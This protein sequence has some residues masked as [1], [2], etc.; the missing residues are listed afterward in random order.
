VLADDALEV[1]EHVVGSLCEDIELLRR[2]LEVRVGV[3]ASIE[4]GETEDG[5]EDE[6][7]ETGL[8]ARRPET[9]REH[10]EEA[11]WFYLQ[12]VEKGR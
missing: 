8:V 2:D 4:A 6:E 5:D 11:V 10:V 1:A 9:T 3:V 7:E 12:I